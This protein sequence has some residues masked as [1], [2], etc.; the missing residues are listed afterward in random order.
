MKA[1]LGRQTVHRGHGP[2]WTVALVVVLVL[3]IE[4]LSCHGLIDYDYDLDDEDESIGSRGIPRCEGGHCP[5]FKTRYQHLGLADPTAALL[6]ARS[7][8]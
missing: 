2:A 5:S 1:S 6:A 8:R 4:P 7:E 3:G